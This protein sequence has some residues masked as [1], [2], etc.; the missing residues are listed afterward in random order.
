[1]GGP[2]SNGKCSPKK[3]KRRHRLGEAHDHRGR[4]WGHRQP[5]EA[6]TSRPGPQRKH[7]LA[8]TRTS[9]FRP[10]QLGGTRGLSF[11]APSI[12]GSHR[13]RIHLLAVTQTHLPVHDSAW[14]PL[15]KCRPFT[16]STG[17]CRKAAA[18]G[19]QGPQR[20]VIL[21]CQ[22]GRDGWRVFRDRVTCVRLPSGDPLVLRGESPSTGCSGQ[23]PRP[24]GAQTA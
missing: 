4:A 10:P 22:G 13:T 12:C 5:A 14:A 3:Q 21:V 2:E 23:C 7:S 20:R 15:G 6:G 17:N 18:Q 11:S 24:G 19:L 9:D 16:G 1:M 8:D